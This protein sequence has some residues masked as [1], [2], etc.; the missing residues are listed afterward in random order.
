MVRIF[1]E[2]AIDHVGGLTGNVRGKRLKAYRLAH[3][4]LESD[5]RGL[6]SVVGRPSSQPVEKSSSKAVDIAAEVLRLIV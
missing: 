3:E 2:H 6:L 4:L 5:R 1:R